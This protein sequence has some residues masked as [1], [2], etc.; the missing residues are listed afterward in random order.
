MCGS[1]QKKPEPT[2]GQPVFRVTLPGSSPVEVTDQQTPLGALLS[3]LGYDMVT[4]PNPAI[5]YTW[6][7]SGSRRAIDALLA[8][9]VV[10]DIT[11]SPPEMIEVE[12]E[13]L[14]LALDGQFTAFVQK[15]HINPVKA[16]VAVAAR[17]DLRKLV[18]LL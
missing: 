17:C 10:E 9:G 7:L 6:L 12:K 15:F 18:G 2:T 16:R 1:A 13:K 5:R 8:A 14:A 11:P 3:A 4:P